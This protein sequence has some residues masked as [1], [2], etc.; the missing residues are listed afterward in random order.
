MNIQIL[1]QTSQA[2]HVPGVTDMKGGDP[3]SMMSEALQL[4]MELRAMFPFLSRITG[5]ERRDALNVYSSVL[6]TM[7]EEARYIL[8]EADTD[9]K[10]LKWIQ[11]IYPN[12]TIADAKKERALMQKL[13]EAD[14]DAAGQKAMNELS[15]FHSSL[16]SRNIQHSDR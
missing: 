13:I 2:G 1:Q 5:I 7:Q 6:I 4:R 15:V 10:L 14:T 9:E 3:M 8:L 12:A 16:A 11:G